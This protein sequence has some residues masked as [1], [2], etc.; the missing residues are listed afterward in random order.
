MLSK[1]LA[2]YEWYDHPEGPKFVETHRDR[3]RTSGHWLF[4]PRRFSTF[5][6]WLGGDELWLIHF[7]RLHLHMIEPSGAH[8]LLRLGTDIGSGERPVAVV[9]SSCWQAAEFPEG[10][11]FAFG[12]NVCAP[13]FLF[14][15]LVMA[16]RDA[17]ERE[18]PAHGALI[19][20]LTR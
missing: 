1:I 2:S 17:L 20:R 16:R 10:V 5:H 18:H 11:E 8:T 9:P 15:Q 3:H 4:M 12:T 7:G 14:E 6:K 13:P 19:R